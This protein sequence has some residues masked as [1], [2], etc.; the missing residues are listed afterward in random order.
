MKAAVIHGLNDIRIEE[1][2]E[3]QIGPDEIL[4]QVRAAGV[5]ST[6]VKQL[7]G[8][9]PPR[10]IPSVLGHELAG[11]IA[12]TGSR[13]VDW[14]AGQRVAVYPIAA[15]GQ[16]YFC[17]LG[18]HSLCEKEF[19]LGRGVDGAF[20]EYCRV[21]AEIL[22]LGGVVDIGSLPFE[23]AVLIEPLS[24]VISASRQC[25]TQVDDTVAVVGCGPMGQLN[26]FA[27]KRAGAKVIAVDFKSD[28]LAEAA[29]IGADLCLNPKDKDVPKAI[30]E[31]TDQR[32][33]D[34]V[35][36]A[37]G[38][39]D[40]VSASIPY[41]RKGGLINI[42]GG[43]PQGD[44]LEID[45]RWLHYGEIYLTGTFGS[46]VTDFLQAH[47]WVQEDAGTIGKILSHTCR[48]EDIVDAVARVKEGKGTK[49]AV[50][51]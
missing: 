9:S 33:A 28:R 2:P 22:H 48:L 49:T 23:T 51:M 37:V 41:V 6:D 35:I 5:C 26:I 10:S 13:V 17:Q 19:G 7:A 18:K 50:L 14:R 20:A 30:Q 27:S 46:S 1:L 45:P 11:T 24:C 8:L 36:V 4:V 21:P 25:R 40:A 43:T 15:C 12:E 39:V 3:P 44:V 32:G 42:F 16:C 38:F 47:A 31:V 34:I 29:S